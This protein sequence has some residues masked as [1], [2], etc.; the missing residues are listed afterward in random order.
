MENFIEAKQ[1]ISDSKNIYV[2]CSETSEAVSS[3]LALFYTLKNLG[4][5]VNLIMDPPAGGLPENLKFL[6]PSLDFISYPKNLV[7]SI[8]DSVAKISQIYYEKNDQ[9]FKIHLGLASGNVKKDNVSFYYAEAKPD[10]IITVGIKD[11]LGAL[12][13]KLDSF[14]F[15]LDSTIL[16]IDNSKDNKNFGKINLV[17]EIPLSEIIFN[18]TESN[19]PASGKESATCLLTSLVVYTENFKKNITA[20]VFQMASNLMKAG[21]DLKEINNNLKII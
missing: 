17:G 8:P 5:N 11:Y 2:V 15:L 6:S 1:L 19:P 10:L 12:D 14:G 7:I 21:A 20:E 4:K 16:N 13:E 18:L 9:T 3:V